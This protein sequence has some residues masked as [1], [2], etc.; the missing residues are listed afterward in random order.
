MLPTPPLLSGVFSPPSTVRPLLPLSSV[1]LHRGPAL[2]RLTQEPRSPAPGLHLQ[3]LPHHSLPRPRW[4]AFGGWAPATHTLLFTG[5][6]HGGCRGPALLM[7][8][9]SRGEEAL[10]SGVSNTAL[11]WTTAPGPRS[12]Q[13]SA[14]GHRAPRPAG[15]CS[16]SLLPCNMG[17]AKALLGFL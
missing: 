14:R 11:D 5:L 13:A 17:V 1:I 15:G 12:L 7:G 6:H 16:C 8:D 2:P 4:G 10:G 9:G 3:C